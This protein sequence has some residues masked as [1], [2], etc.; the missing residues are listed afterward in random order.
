MQ[1]FDPLFA[2][3]I[4]AGEQEALALMLANRCPEHMFC[5]GDGRPLQ[6]LAMLNMSDRGV[7]LEELLRR[8][9]RNQKLDEHYTKAFRERQL[10]EGQRRRIQCDGLSAKS[11]FRKL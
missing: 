11:R 7:S 10:A 9:G 3:S 2:E 8:L 5:S 1:E 6:A 4:D